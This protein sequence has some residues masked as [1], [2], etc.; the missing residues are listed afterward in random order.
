MKDQAIELDS[1]NS[2]DWSRG[3]ADE[4]SSWRDI[5]SKGTEAHRPRGAS[6]KTESWVDRCMLCRR[7]RRG[8]AGAWTG[9]RGPG[10]EVRLRR[11]DFQA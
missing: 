7:D 6:G 1:E 8:G 10:T 11:L 4:H 3:G 9:G 2:R 5:L